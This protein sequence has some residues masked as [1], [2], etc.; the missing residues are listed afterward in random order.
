MFFSTAQVVALAFA[1]T[2]TATALPDEFDSSLFLPEEHKQVD[3]KT[4][5]GYNIVTEVQQPFHPYLELQC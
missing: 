5:I 4:I 3:G 2:N 1:L